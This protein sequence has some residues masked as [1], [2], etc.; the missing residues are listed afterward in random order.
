MMRGG[1]LGP[2]ISILPPW[3]GFVLHPPSPQEIPGVGICKD[4]F[5]ELHNRSSNK[6]NLVLFFFPAESNFCHTGDSDW[7]G[8]VC[9]FDLMCNFA[10]LE[11]IFRT[12]AHNINSIIFSCRVSVGIFFLAA[13]NLFASVCAFIMY[14]VRSS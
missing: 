6:L 4:F 10:K 14:I 9:K 2:E 11:P 7:C 12:L 1:K 8:K 5:L 3:K 13:E